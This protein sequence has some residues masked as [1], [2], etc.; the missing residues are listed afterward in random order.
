MYNELEKYVLI[1]ADNV[2][3]SIPVQ[4]KPVKEKERNSIDF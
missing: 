4:L 2:P 1:H 3:L